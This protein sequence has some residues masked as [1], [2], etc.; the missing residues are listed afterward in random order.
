MF[1]PG[2]QSLI[3]LWR[4]LPGVGRIPARADLDPAF[5]G[6]RL[7]LAFMLRRI[8]GDA[9]FRLAGE[10]VE[11]MA[12]R[13]LAGRR[14][15]SL[16]RE[17]GR[18]LAVPALARACREARPVLLVAEPERSRV[19]LEIVVAP[20]RSADD[21]ADRLIGLMQ[22][23][24]ALP[25]AGESFGLLTA[26]LAVGVGAPGRPPLTLAAVDGRRVA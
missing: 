18:D 25:L 6:R 26:R 14:W 8:A 10:E 7:P 5:L 13:P 17:D 21:S 11:R 22:P 9:V 4:A 12:G 23:L 16:W 19:R 24:G 20:L 2:T 1:H 15:S 3:D